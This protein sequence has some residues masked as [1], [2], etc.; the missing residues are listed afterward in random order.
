M[1]IKNWKD[2]KISSVNPLC[3]IFSKLNGYVEEININKYLAMVPTNES[4]E[5]L[6]NMKNCGVK[7]KV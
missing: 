2:I 6:K 3:F 1:T 5:N 4:K 7:S